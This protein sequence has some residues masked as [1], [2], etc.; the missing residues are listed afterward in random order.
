MLGHQTAVVFVPCLQK[1]KE[2]RARV[3]FDA[4]AE[5]LT[6]DEVLLAHRDARARQ[7]KI[8]R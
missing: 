5:R 8:D 7:A 6:A 4:V 2:Q 3:R 1:A